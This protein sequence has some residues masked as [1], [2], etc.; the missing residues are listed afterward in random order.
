ML[1][2]P[3]QPVGAAL[4]DQGRRLHQGPHTLLEEER[5][6]FRPLDQEL[7]E[8]AEG[9]VSAE[10]RSEQLVSALGRQGIDP[11]LAVVGLAAPGVAV[12]GAVVDK[13][14]EARGGGRR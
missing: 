3:G 7:L 11:E 5:I 12:L 2:G 14:K 4:A 9:R 8:R 13:E 1:D 6:R 10:E